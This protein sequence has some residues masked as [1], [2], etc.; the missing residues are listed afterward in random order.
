MKPST[1][2]TMLL[3][4]LKDKKYVTHVVPLRNF[5][6][7]HY[8][9]ITL[10]IIE[11]PSQLKE[12]MFEEQPT[13]IVL[14]VSDDPYMTWAGDWSHLGCSRFNFTMNKITQVASTPEGLLL[15]CAHTDFKQHIVLAERFG[16]FR[17]PRPQM[18]C[19]DVM[20]P[21]MESYIFP[22]TLDDPIL[23]LK[24]TMANNVHASVL[25]LYKFPHLTNS[26][27]LAT[28]VDQMTM[29]RLHFDGCM[30]LAGDFTMRFTEENK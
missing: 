6:L 9:S 26:F 7:Q 1:Q 22:G 14:T 18:P 24:T 11:L 25:N 28:N 30:A 23:Y 20:E 13:N 12:M 2:N 19:L 8:D 29:C 15:R 10:L 16:P 17:D 21:L 4:W 3:G 27:N 5:H